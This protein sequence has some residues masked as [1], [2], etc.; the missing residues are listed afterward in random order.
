MEFC[1]KEGLVLLADEVCKPLY[2]LRSA[3]YQGAL[4]IKFESAISLPVCSENL[5]NTIPLCYLL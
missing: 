3:D 2:Y 5:Y 4:E 1:K